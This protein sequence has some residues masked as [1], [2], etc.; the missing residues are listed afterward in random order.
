MKEKYE[1]LTQE[2]KSKIEGY[3]N[4]IKDMNQL[5]DD[6]SMDGESIADEIR[7]DAVDELIEYLKQSLPMTL[8]SYADELS[9]DEDE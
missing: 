1:N 6:F 4:A 9:P 7:R 5:M 3:E 2:A 8:A